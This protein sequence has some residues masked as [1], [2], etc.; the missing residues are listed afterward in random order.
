MN[1]FVGAR[2]GDDGQEGGP[3]IFFTEALPKVL[4]DAAEA[5]RDVRGPQGQRRGRGNNLRIL[6]LR[7]GLRRRILRTDA[8]AGVALR[9]R[10]D[11]N[12]Q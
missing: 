3:R 1:S 10:E 2:G 11:R 8:M 5:D 9:G 6:R 12:A 7:R 4:R